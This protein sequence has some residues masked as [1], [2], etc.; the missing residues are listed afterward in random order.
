MRS[1]HRFVSPA[2]LLIAQGVSATRPLGAQ[3]MKANTDA[4]SAFSQ[5]AATLSKLYPIEQ[6]TMSTAADAEYP[7][8][9]RFCWE[10]FR[11]DPDR[12][13]RLSEAFR[14][15]KGRVSWMLGPPSANAICLVATRSGTNQFVGYPAVSQTQTPPKGLEP[16]A[17]DE[18]VDQAVADVPS[19][20]SYLE[21]YLGLEQSASKSFDPQLIAPP[22]PPPVES[23]PVDFVER[24]MHVAW[25]VYGSASSDRQMLHFSVADK[26]WRR[27]EGHI[28]EK[29]S[30]TFP[31]LTSIQET[32][33]AYFRGEEVEALR[34]ECLRARAGTSTPSA[35]R[36]LD[37][38]ILLC[39]WARHLRGDLFLRAP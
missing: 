32:E 28:L 2:L 26:E 24:G 12:L 14:S 3:Q 34:Q 20:C 11:A 29:D 31:L 13:S 36:G 4:P 16:L 22:D 37:K 7:F 27:I 38:L 21:R 39:H 30:D 35:I 1:A 23:A 19:L 8:A 33:S 10:F 6:W 18:F 15:Y 17:D 25:I 9:P 5:L